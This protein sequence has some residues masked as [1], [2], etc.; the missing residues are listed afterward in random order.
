[1]STRRKK[2]WFQLLAA[3]AAVLLFRYAAP[4]VTTVVQE[5]AA[6]LV[7]LRWSVAMDVPITKIKFAVAPG[8]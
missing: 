4:L 2:R 7:S 6:P 1:L 3:A 8:Q 5:L